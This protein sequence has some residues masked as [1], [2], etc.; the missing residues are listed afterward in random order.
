MLIQEVA[1]KTD[2]KVRILLEDGTSFI[3]YA[4][5]ARKYGIREEEDLSDETIREIMDEVLTRRSRLR[6][7]NLLKSS[8]RTV[9]QLRSTLVRDGYPEEIIDQALNY[10]ASYHYTDDVR[11][12]RNFIRQM[13]GKRSRKQIEFDLM[14]RGVDRDTVRAALS[15]ADEESPEED[16]D[17]PAILA[18]ARKRGFHPGTADQA[19]SEKMVRY[20]LGKGFSFSSI[21]SAFSPEYFR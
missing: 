7:M 17:I 4:S 10:V 13:S 12:A 6:C 20:L 8:D 15:E 11:Y 3:L 18:F 2:K 9:D 1:K 5:E 21:R 14:K 16:P 19:Q